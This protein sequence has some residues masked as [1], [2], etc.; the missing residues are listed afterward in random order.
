MLFKACHVLQELSF[1]F[2]SHIGLIISLILS[3]SVTHICLDNPEGTVGTIY[4]SC[5]GIPLN[6]VKAGL[7]NFICDNLPEYGALGVLI[8]KIAQRYSECHCGLKTWV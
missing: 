3:D 7:D 5:W 1:P 8:W 2:W 6:T 4:N